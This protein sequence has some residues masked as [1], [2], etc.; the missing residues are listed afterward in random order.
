MAE[1]LGNDYITLRTMK[2]SGWI[3]NCNNLPLYYPKLVKRSTGCKYQ[4]ESA[5]K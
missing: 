5:G 4:T 3:R 2:H 1:I